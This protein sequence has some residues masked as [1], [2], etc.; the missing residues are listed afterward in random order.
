[1][2]TA[3]RLAV[4]Q[5]EADPNTLAWQHKPAKPK[6][7]QERGQKTEAMSGVG[8]TTACNLCKQLSSCGRQ[9]AHLQDGNMARGT[10]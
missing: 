2:R 10:N 1:M 3:G 4:E 7:P 9:A 6:C 5:G 8:K